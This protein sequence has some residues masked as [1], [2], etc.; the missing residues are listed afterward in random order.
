MNERDFAY[1]LQGFFELTGAQQLD[2]AQV[3]IIKEHLQLVF[4]KKTQTI[5]EQPNK[6]QT[7]P[8]P[9]KIGPIQQVFENPFD[10]QPQITCEQTTVDLSSTGTKA[11]LSLPTILTC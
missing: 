4:E 10:L 2:Q 6:I 9:F 11:Q 7:L 8:T 1:W 3:K 5:Y